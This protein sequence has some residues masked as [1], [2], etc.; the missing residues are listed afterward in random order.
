MPDGSEMWFLN[1]ELHREDGPAL[2]GSDGTQ[3]WRL[4]HEKYTF[5]EWLEELDCDDKTKTLLALKW[6]SR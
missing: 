2:I 1:G 5:T 4:Y 3:E 6:S